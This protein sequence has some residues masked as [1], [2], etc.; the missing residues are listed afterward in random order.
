MATLT[1]HRK[2]FFGW[3]KRMP[4]KTQY[5]IDQVLNRVVPE[6]EKHGFIWYPDF[7][8]NNPQEIG[9]NEIPLQ[10]RQG[11]SWPTVQIYFVPK[12]PFF[13]FHFSALPAF[14]R[15]PVRNNIPRQQAIVFYGPASFELLRGASTGRQLDS[16][17][18]IDIFFFLFFGFSRLVRYVLNWRKFLDSEVDAAIA[19]L[20]ILFDIF[21][22]G[23]SQ[24]WINHEFGKI[25]DHVMLIS[26]WKR[27]DELNKIKQSQV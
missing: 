11:D 13:R 23:I 24:E 4:A 18:G 7:A 2:R 20:P 21:D 14:C 16:I 10:K 8:D 12:G 19:L 26:S 1:G 25:N 22:R 17:F 5:L 27:W 15:N 9:A 6:F 3:K